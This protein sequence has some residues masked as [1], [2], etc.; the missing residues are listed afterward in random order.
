MRTCAKGLVG[1]LQLLPP[2]PWPSS[3]V[4]LLRLLSRGEAGG[5]G[6]KGESLKGCCRRAVLEWGVSGCTEPGREHV[7]E[8]V[9]SSS[10]SLCLVG[11]LRTR[12][13]GCLRGASVAFLVRA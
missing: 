3:G 10:S 5:E 8:W 1:R 2:I 7:T 11:L 12:G 4:A 13:G 6:R 9:G